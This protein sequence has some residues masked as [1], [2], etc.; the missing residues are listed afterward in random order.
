MDFI[1]KTIL[2]HCTLRRN[3]AFESGGGTSNVQSADIA[4]IN[5]SFIS[6]TALEYGGGSYIGTVD[7][8]NITSTAFTTNHADNE[9]DSIYMIGNAIAEIN[10]PSSGMA[11]PSI[12]SSGEEM[13]DAGKDG[14]FV[15]LI[16]DPIFANE[17]EGVSFTCQNSMYDGCYI[18]E[19]SSESSWLNNCVD[20]PLNWTCHHRT[21]SF[22]QDFMDNCQSISDYGGF[23]TDSC[24]YGYEYMHEDGTTANQGCCIC[25]GGLVDVGCGGER[26]S[27]YEGVVMAYCSC[28]AHNG[29]GAVLD[30]GLEDL[31]S[32]TEI[33]LTDHT[34][35]F[36]T[37]Y[38][39]GT[40][41]LLVL[42]LP[43]IV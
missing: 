28:D 14:R 22:C 18:K 29:N 25:N 4:I 41:L 37:A 9:G 36:N 8:A 20:S 40:N 35:A 38:K 2:Q 21:E 31:A 24:A 43:I 3:T 34:F 12:I 39:G 10:C 26:L 27:R 32:L 16:S 7:I 13:L 42:L 5:C 30:V 15:Y 23:T 19:Q 1:S 6:N 33:Q 11:Y 17:V